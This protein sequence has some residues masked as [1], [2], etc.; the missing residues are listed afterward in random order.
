MEIPFNYIVLIIFRTLKYRNQKMEIERSA[1]IKSIKEA[2]K[3]ERIILDKKDSL[4]PLKEYGEIN[5]ADISVIGP[6]ISSNFYPKPKEN[7][8][9]TIG[10]I[11][12]L[13]PRKRNEILIKSFL[14]ADIE[15][16]QLLIA[17]KGPELNNLKRI[18]KNDPR[19]KFLGF[20]SD[21]EVNDFYNSLDVFVFPSIDEGYGMPIVEAMACEKPVITLEDGDIDA[22]VKNKNAVLNINGEKIKQYGYLDSDNENK[23]VYISEKDN[24][25]FYKITGPDII[26]SLSGESESIIRTLFK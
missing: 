23:K 14:D 7:D 3:C 24:I 11:A 10:T 22:D 21:E 19:I 8:I 16:S 17:G 5:E 2:I 12:R 9:Y 26:S 20:I 18:A 4:Y 1:L 25:P 15:D 6:A 13:I